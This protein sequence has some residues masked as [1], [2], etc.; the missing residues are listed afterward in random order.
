MTKLFSRN[1]LLLAFAIVLLVFCLTLGCLTINDKAIADTEFVKVDEI[2]VAHLTDTHYY[3]QRLCY[4]EGDARDTADTN[5]FYNYV[6]KH[7]TKLWLEAE[8]VFDES[9][10]KIVEQNPNYLVLSGDTAQDGEFLGHVDVANKLRKLQNQIRATQG[11]DSFQIFVVLGNHDLYNPETYRFD[12]ED[13]TREEGYYTT[14]REAVNIYAGLG[15]PNMTEAQA[16][17]FY[18]QAE[19][20]GLMPSDY[21]FVRSDLSDDFTYSWQFLDRN[22]DDEVM[23]FDASTISAD[24]LSLGA[25]ETQDIVRYINTNSEFSA[26]S[27]LTYLYQQNRNEYKYDIRVGEMTF[28][29][30]RNDD[31]FSFSGIDGVLSDVNSNHVLGGQV[32]DSTQEYLTQCDAQ[33]LIDPLGCE[34]QTYGATHHSM[35]QHYS[36]EEEITTGFVL[37]NWEEVSDFIADLGIKYVYTGHMHANDISSKISMNGNQLIDIESSASVGVASM[38]KF[39][40]VESGTFGGDY[41][42]RA[43]FKISHNEEIKKNSTLASQSLFNKVFADDKYGYVEDNKLENYLVMTSGSEK[44]KNYSDYS[45][46]RVYLNAVENT[47]DGYLDLSTIDMLKGM[48]GGLVGNIDLLSSYGSEIEILIENLFDQINEVVL[49]DYT[50]EGDNEKF[51]GKDNMKIFGY[52]EEMV[53]VVLN[54]DMSSDGS[55]IYIF[56]MFMGL[57]MSH[58]KGT[59]VNSYEDLDADTQEALEYIKSGKMVNAILD[60]LLDK[61][62]GLYFIIDKLASSDLDLSANLEDSRIGTLIGNLS[63]L[64][65]GLEIDLEKFNLGEILKGVGDV[66]NNM[67]PMQFDFANMSVGEIIDDVVAKYLTDA[68]VNGLSEYVYNIGVSFGVDEGKENYSGTPY[69][70]GFTLISL[71]ENADTSYYGKCTYV[72]NDEREEIITV[73]N[74]KLPSMITANFGADPSESF[75]VTY[76]TD[77]RITDGVIQYAEKTDDEV[78]TSYSTKTMTTEILGTNKT[79]I[80]LGMWAQVGYVEL[81]RHCVTVSNLDANTTYWYRVGDKNKG[82][83]SEWYTVKTAPADTTTDFEVFIGTDVQGSSKSTYDLASE[84]YKNMMEV[85]PNGIDFAINA[86]DTVDNSRNLNQFKWMLNTTDFYANNINV[87]SPGNHDEKYF[88]YDSEDDYVA[89]YGGKSSGANVSKYNY[90]AKHFNYDLTRDQNQENGYYMSFDYSGVHFVVLNTNDIDEDNRLGADQYEWLVEDLEGSEA[91]YKVVVMHKSLYSAGSHVHDKDVVGM[92]EQLTPIFNKNGVNL[93]IG[94]HDHTY[95]ETFYL[96]E[97]GEKVQTDANGSNKIGKE[98]TLYLTMGT[99]GDKFYAYKYGEEVNVQTGEDIHVDEDKLADPT[100]G[101][102][103]FK[104]GELYYYGY[105]YLR[106]VDENGEVTFEIKPISKAPVMGKANAMLGII[107]LAVTGVVFLVSLVGGICYKKKNK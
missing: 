61:E 18:A 70:N 94:G 101:K 2:N 12:N 5:Y 44:I 21:D 35:I 100:F 63:G 58:N 45:E 107:I 17:D 14:R 34:T 106:E 28:V 93:V 89:W 96:N 86:G 105:Q 42:E 50:Y 26:S 19:T 99:V 13:G 1:R 40:K 88:E 3:P 59:D 90:L 52:L 87:I 102:L 23:T 48:V 69:V 84:L 95:S 60:A 47:L 51:I 53:D 78:P 25:F 33:G 43:S 79:Y 41:A 67:L 57:Y 76:Y 83:M 11:N 56:D 72:A 75:A 98:G 29:A 10:L 6:M 71:Q 64:I 103:V 24:D 66:L 20:E 30:T 77:R 4:V 36:M 65:G 7:A 38:V 73:E 55:G 62:T 68:L 39:T 8:M 85:F 32:Q 97:K 37:Y 74:G 49:A 81:G 9:L 16:N 31:K 15:Y 22:A 91:E 82:Y 104:D 27:D 80:D 54:H 92:R 46:R